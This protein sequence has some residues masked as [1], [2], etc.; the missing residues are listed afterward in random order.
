MYTSTVTQYPALTDVTQGI[1]VFLYDVAE[2]NQ[3]Q[4]G[5]W[6]SV[7][8]FC[9][10]IIDAVRSCGDYISYIIDVADVY[11]QE[12]TIPVFVGSAVAIGVTIMI[13]DFYRGR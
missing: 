8:K 11:I 4:N 10:N 5:W 7:S 1:E 13:I 6:N 3:N 9:N 2:A 12:N